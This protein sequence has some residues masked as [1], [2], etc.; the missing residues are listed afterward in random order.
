VRMDPFYDSS[1]L[2]VAGS[3]PGGGL[4]GGAS[5]GLS[6]LN[7]GFADATV[8]YASPSLFG[9][10]VNGEVGVAAQADEDY[11][12]GIS[13]RNGGVEAGA[14]RYDPSSGASWA[15]AAAV[16]RANRAHLSYSW[17]SGAM[18]GVSYETVEA[19]ELDE[20]EFLYLVGRVPVIPRVV[21]SAAVGHTTGGELIPSPAGT[22]VHAGLSYTIVDQVQVRGV[23]SY[24][25]S[26]VGEN[27]AIVSLGMSYR[28]SLRRATE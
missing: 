19:N 21:A 5:F 13:Y 28:F 1:T 17:G 11:G 3:I 27:P 8:S 20:Q 14:Q 24:L 15:Q 18:V 9:V 23:A 4:F 2:D 7:N 10:T 12:F 22:A 6:A 25:D 26:Q 16:E